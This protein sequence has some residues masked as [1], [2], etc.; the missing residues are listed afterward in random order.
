M[1]E[2]SDRLNRL[3]KKKPRFFFLM[4]E[5]KEPRHSSATV[6]RPVL[7]PNDVSNRI[8]LDAY[9]AQLMPKSGILTT[10]RI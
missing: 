6:L 3:V 5:R 9:T 8:K 7:V 4:F 10:N 1:G 2:N